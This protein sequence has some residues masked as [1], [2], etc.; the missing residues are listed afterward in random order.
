MFMEIVLKE[1]Y[2]VICHYRE[3]NN[4]YLL[5]YDKSKEKLN[6]VYFDFNI[7]MDFITTNSMWW[8]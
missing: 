2:K 1:E 7:L 8:I 3:A 4:K 6:I 5:I